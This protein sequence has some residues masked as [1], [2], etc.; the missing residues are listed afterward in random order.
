MEHTKGYSANV[1]LTL[2]INGLRLALSHL[3]PHGIVVRD[4][5]DPIPPGE[6]NIFLKIDGT[7]KRRR[8]YLPEGVPGPRQL[9][10]LSNA[11]F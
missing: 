6:A 11:P 8:V 10:P 4:N 1:A 2:V 3:E 5:C 9:V 7:T